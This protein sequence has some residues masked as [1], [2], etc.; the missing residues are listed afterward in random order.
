V[1]DS[2]NSE[3]DDKL[4]ALFVNKYNF[5]MAAEVLCYAIFCCQ[6]N[7][8]NDFFLDSFKLRKS[9]KYCW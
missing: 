3:I 5:F 8:L 7:N 2:E 1:N 9:D 6:K 4:D